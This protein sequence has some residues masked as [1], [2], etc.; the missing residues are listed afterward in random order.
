MKKLVTLAI[1]FLAMHISSIAQLSSTPNG[2]NKKAWAGERIGLT[3][4]SIHYDRPAVKGRE[5][6]IWGELVP[7]GF[8]DLG[9]GTSKAAPWRAGANENTTIE[10]STDVVIEGKPLA[11]GK[12]GFFIAVG[13]EESILIFS[14]N[15]SSWGSYFYDGKEDALRVTIKQQ[16]LDKVVERLKYEFINQTENSAVIALQ[17][18]KWSFPFKVET[19]LAKNQLQS[20]RN[21]LRGDKGFDWKAW[22]QAAE[23]CA[24]HKTNL[25]EA[26]GWADYSI[27]GQFI[28]EKNFRTLSVK[29][30][31]LKLQGKETEAAALMNEAVPFGTVN[32]VQG[33][34]RQLLSAGKVKEASDIF[35]S[36]YKKFPNT[37]TTN[38]G[39]ARVLS[40]EGK[41]KEALKYA[42]AG[43]G[44]APDP[45]NKANA[46]SM[47]EKLKAGKD[48]NQ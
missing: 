42:T 15:T 33:Y 11:A 47:I 38:M 13:K 14:K 16:S 3:D 27:S 39:M 31:I 23:W 21:E 25:D 29:S 44:Q 20:F 30:E 19:D 7:F 2:G 35:K 6:K 46:E 36:N 1:I 24:E 12:Y 4:V 43:L 28:G 41:Y 34:A 37:F 22:A 10:F 8:T 32:E 48:I 26:L 40:S 9:F 18:E 17:W 5:G 45:A